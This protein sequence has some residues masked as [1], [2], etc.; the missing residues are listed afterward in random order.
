MAYSSRGA[1]PPSH[2]VAVPSIEIA[3]QY[4]VAGGP[5][6]ELSS[7]G[8]LTG[9]ADFVN[10]WQQPALQRLVDYCL[11]ALRACDRAP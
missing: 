6:V 8:T 1:C 10:G 7:Q 3:I 11:N 4:P 2:P 5:G 9:H